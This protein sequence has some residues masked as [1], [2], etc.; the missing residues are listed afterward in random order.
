MAQAPP[1]GD[2][3]PAHAASC[4]YMS[5][6][7]DQQNDPFLGNYAAALGPYLVPVAN[8]NVAT[9]TE[10][11]ELALNCQHQSVPTAFLLLHDDGKLHIYLQLDKFHTRMCM[12]PTQ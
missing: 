9:P 8:Q 4:D 7:Q 10:V 1:L 11:Q 6:F 2:L 12:P 3:A 5:F